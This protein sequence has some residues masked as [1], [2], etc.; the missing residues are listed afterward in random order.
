[1]FE[2]TLMQFDHAR[3]DLYVFACCWF[4]VNV[5]MCCDHVLYYVDVLK[6][7]LYR[8]D[9]IFDRLRRDDAVYIKIQKWPLPAAKKY[10][11]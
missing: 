8:F 7:C 9:I 6:Y 11:C 3:Y 4:Y 1:M 5:L 10:F 2:I